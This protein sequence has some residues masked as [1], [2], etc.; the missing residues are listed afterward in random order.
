M[1]SLTSEKSN[2]GDSHSGPIMMARLAEDNDVSSARDAVSGFLAPDVQFDQPSLR[3]LIPGVIFRG[4][5][6]LMRQR[7][8]KPS[9]DVD[10]D[11]KNDFMSVGGDRKTSAVVD[12]VQSPKQ[13]RDQTISNIDIHPRPSVTAGDDL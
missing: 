7:V 5:V 10:A 6:S 3:S 2:A 9:V 13:Q 1:L 8:P 11:L 12:K 4:I